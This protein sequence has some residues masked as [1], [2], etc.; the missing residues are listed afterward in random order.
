MLA[1]ELFTKIADSEA[2]EFYILAANREGEVYLDDEEET[3]P[4]STISTDNNL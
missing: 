2:V 4:A 3:N 1:D